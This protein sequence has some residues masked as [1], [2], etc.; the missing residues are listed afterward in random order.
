[1]KVRFSD[2]QAIAG[3]FE[4][5]DIYVNDSFAGNIVSDGQWWSVHTMPGKPELIKDEP[6]KRVRLANLAEIKR[7]IVEGLSSR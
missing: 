2:I 1:M 5:V 4:H 7:L 6:D 3:A